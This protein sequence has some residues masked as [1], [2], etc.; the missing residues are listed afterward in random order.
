MPS[1]T[2]QGIIISAWPCV[3]K[4]YFTKLKAE[5]EY[6]PIDLDSSAYDLKSSAGTVKYVEDIEAKARGSPNSIL[7]VSSHAEVRQL[8][9]DK[10][11]KYLAVSI[12]DLEDWKHR[13]LKRVNDDPNHENAHR[14][15]LK[16]GIAEWDIWKAREAGEEGPKIVLGNGQYLADLDVEIHKLWKREW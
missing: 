14:G 5:E 10:G 13:Q 4:T 7:L 6:P 16:K 1:Q 2:E 9:M 11:L 3:G 8:L 15:L 12:D